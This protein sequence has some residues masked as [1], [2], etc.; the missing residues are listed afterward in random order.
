MSPRSSQTPAGDEP[1]DCF[2]PFPEPR[3]FPGGW[4]LTGLASPPSRPAVAPAWHTPFPMPRTIP[5]GWDVTDWL[6]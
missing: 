5:E 3:T 4:D 6:K 2:D 1:S